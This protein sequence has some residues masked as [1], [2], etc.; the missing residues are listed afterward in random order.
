[1]RVAEDDFRHFCS[2]RCRHR[3][4]RLKDIK[5]EKRSVAGRHKHDHRFAEGPPDAEKD[6]REDA[7]CG[8]GENCALRCLPFCSAES[9]TCFG[10]VARDRGERV[11]RHSIDD[12]NNG[13]RE[14][15]AS[16][17]GVK[18]V[19][20]TEDVLRKCGEFDE[21]E[22]ANGSSLLRHDLEPGEE[23][24]I[25]LVGLKIR[26]VLEELGT[27]GQALLTALMFNGTIVASIDAASI[28]KI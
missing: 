1:M 14:R 19:R 5:R 12:G 17:E 7:R 20:R 11:V 27:N 22:Y 24:E 3:P 15:N 16:D 4:H 21:R 18:P 25:E 28:R 10:H 13:E 9:E 26:A 23:V 8:G 2:D 6:G